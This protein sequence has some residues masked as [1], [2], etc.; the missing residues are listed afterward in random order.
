MRLTPRAIALALFLALAATALYATRLTEAPRYLARDEIGFGRQAY[1]FATTGRDLDGNYF[2]L[3]FGEPAYH[4]GRDPLLI[5]VTAA[6][7]KVRPLSDFIVRLPNALV[8]VLDI[9]LMFFVG[10]RI[11]KSDWL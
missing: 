4:V 10:R 7:L 1:T 2:P 3:F 11:F 5:Y 9:V 6:L 8:G